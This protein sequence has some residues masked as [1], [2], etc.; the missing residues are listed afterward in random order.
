MQALQ[1]APLAAG[2][3]ILIAATIPWLWGPVIGLA[4][5]GVVLAGFASKAENKLKNAE[6]T[7][8]PA[9]ISHFTATLEGLFSIRSYHAEDRFDR[10]NLEKIDENHKFLHAQLMTKSWIALDL[11]I[12]ASLMIYFCT[13]LVVLYRNDKDM[14]SVAG[15]ALSNALQMLVF[16]QWTVRMVGEVQGQMSS[17]GQLVYYGNNVAREAPAEIP[18][19]ITDPNW[20]TTGTIQFSNLVLKYHKFGVAVLKNVS[21]TIYPKEKVGIVGRTGSGKSTLLISLLRIVE[22]F[23]GKITIDDLDVSTIGL[24]DLR[25]K[26]AII[27]QVRNPASN[28]FCAAS[29]DP[30]TDEEIWR[31]LEAVHL[32]EKIRA[33]PNGLETAILVLDEATAAIDMATDAL[34]QDAIKENFSDKT[35]LTIAHRL[36]TIIESDKMWVAVDFGAGVGEDGVLV[37]DAGKVAEFDE[38]LKLLDK[39]NGHFRSLVDQTGAATA[40]KLKE[41]AVQAKAARDARESKGNEPE[42]RQQAPEKAPSIK[43]EKGKGKK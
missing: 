27:P 1:Y 3:M 34:I 20:P 26:I 12:V 25:T 29:L 33:F 19:A 38:P 43:S 16:L 4:A 36:N 23:K 8:K 18:G 41:I 15:L 30:S 6:A 13:L 32:G 11:D 10:D 5:V 37:M 39:P 24:R 42:S 2:A 28:I 40:A 35:V 21:F 22:A 17:V 14:P 7:T 9:V 31:A